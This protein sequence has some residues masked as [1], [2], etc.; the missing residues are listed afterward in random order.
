MVTDVFTFNRTIVELKF[1]INGAKLL[2]VTAFNRT[3][4]ELKYGSKCST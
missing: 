4:V 2:L 3:I 1:Q